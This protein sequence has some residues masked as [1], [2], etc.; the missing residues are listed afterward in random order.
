MMTEY[1]A[2]KL[3]ESMHR[4]LNAGAGGVWQCIAGLVILIVVLLTGT[5]FPPTTG[6]LLDAANAAPGVQQAPTRVELD[7]RAGV[8]VQAL[9]E[10]GT[11]LLPAANA[12]ELVPK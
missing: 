8:E 11:D 1:E 6:R 9:H 10:G 3:A 7:E 4:E 2:R 5:V 12:A